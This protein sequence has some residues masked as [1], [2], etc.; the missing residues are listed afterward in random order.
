MG[1]GLTIALI[2]ATCPSCILHSNGTASDFQKAL[3]DNA[4]VEFADMP[5]TRSEIFPIVDRQDGSLWRIARIEDDEAFFTTFSSIEKAQDC[6]SASI[7]QCKEDALFLCGCDLIYYRGDDSDT[8]Q[9]LQGISAAS[10]NLA[11]LAE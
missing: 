10:I 7:E 5:T 8:L 3:A 9:I 1:L 11:Y 6:Y 2:L 4:N